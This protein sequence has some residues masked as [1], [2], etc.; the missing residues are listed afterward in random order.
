MISTRLSVLE[1]FFSE[2]VVW[3]IFSTETVGTVAQWTL[4]TE[5]AEYSYKRLR[6]THQTG[7]SSKTDDSHASTPCPS[8]TRGGDVDSSDTVGHFDG[9][10]ND[11]DLSMEM[12]GVGVGVGEGGGEDGSG[13]GQGVED[14]LGEDELGRGSGNR[15]EDGHGFGD[16]FGGDGF[17]D[18]DEDEDDG[19]LGVANDSGSH[20]EGMRL[21]YLEDLDTAAK[22]AGVTIFFLGNPAITL[23][24]S[25]TP[26]FS[27]IP[28]PA[29]DRY[30]IYHGCAVH[31]NIDDLASR[32][33]S[34]VQL[35]PIIMFP[36]N[37]AESK[38]SY[39]S[40]R[41][42][43]YYSSSIT[44]ARLWPVLKDGLTSYR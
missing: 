8:P 2:V 12:G 18:G 7:E 36:T 11:E 35:R 34:F 20:L 31:Q 40:T 6:Y 24:P 37:P 19:G 15:D 25:F 5:V 32:L 27:S 3:T 13:H 23:N 30:T 10:P 41:P 33:S 21:S 38:H 43:V 17:E 9:N 4:K 1:E 26:P 22:D 16:G 42:A 39:L 28:D 29:P 44:Y 14:G